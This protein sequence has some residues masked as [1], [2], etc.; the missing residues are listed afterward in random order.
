M[1][2]WH[3][4]V[5]T[6]F[7]VYTTA[8]YWI[9]VGFVVSAAFRS[10]T[11]AFPRIGHSVTLLFG[12]L[13]IFGACSV[14]MVRFYTAAK[15]WGVWWSIALVGKRDVAFTMAVTLAGARFTIAM[16]GFPTRKSARRFCDLTALYTFGMFLSSA[17]TLVHLKRYFVMTTLL[18]D[19]NDSIFVGL[20]AF[21]LF[22]ASDRDE[23]LLPLV[24]SQSVERPKAQLLQLEGKEELSHLLGPDITPRAD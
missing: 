21:Q 18:T 19:C 11:E 1:C 4:P 14:W 20:S 17:L 10:I 8:L 3:L 24:W 12:A 7:W 13:A 22:R 6:T 16:M 9:L 15:A 5:Y 2:L 23:D